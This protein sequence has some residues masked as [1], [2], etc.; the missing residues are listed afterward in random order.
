MKTKLLLRLGINS[1]SSSKGKENKISAVD[2]FVLFQIK[3]N[4][5]PLL[6]QT[7]CFENEL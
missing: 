2:W 6:H 7:G 1:N 5:S 4:T 3:S